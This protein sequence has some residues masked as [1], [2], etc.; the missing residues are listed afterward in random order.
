MTEID[1]ASRP[2]THEGECC[3]AC[4][5]LVHLALGFCCEKD[6]QD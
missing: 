1:E 3:D 2:H 5:I 6:V 4:G